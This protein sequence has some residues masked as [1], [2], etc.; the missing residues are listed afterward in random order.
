MG[1][2]VASAYA[3]ACADLGVQF[4]Y[5]GVEPHHV[6]DSLHVLST[7]STDDL[8]ERTARF[9]DWL[10]RLDDG[11]HFVMSHPAVRPMSSSDHRPERRQRRVGRAVAGGGSTRADRRAV[12]EVVDR[13]GIELVSVVDL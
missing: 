3:G 10:D 5:R 13:R 6:F 8:A 4:I 1:I 11:V 9:V 7:V 12:R 2:S